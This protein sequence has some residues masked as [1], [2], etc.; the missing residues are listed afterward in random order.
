MNPVTNR[1]G[2]RVMVLVMI[3]GG[4][5]A[6]ARDPLVGVWKFSGSVPAQV[7]VTFTLHEDR[8]FNY[9]ETVAPLTHPAGHVP[10][11]CV[12][13]DSYSGAYS[14]GNGTL[15]LTF[16]GGTVN[17]V[18]GCNETST[19]SPGRPA[20]AADIAAFT[21]Q[22]LILPGLESFSLT[23]TTLTLTP[24]LGNRTTAFAKAP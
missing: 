13:T 7:N 1:L 4:C 12:T 2:W 10:T 18:S 19:N 24:G 11:G 20:T 9:V 6:D 17:A 5:G 16:A 15:T 22:G 3:L 8:T 14:D 21:A 23:S